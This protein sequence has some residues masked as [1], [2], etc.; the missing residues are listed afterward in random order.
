MADRKSFLVYGD[1]ADILC[2][3]SDEQAAELF[4]GMVDYFNTGEDPGFSGAMKF[5]WIPIR[6]QM[7]RDREKYENKCERN[8]TSA[9]KRWNANA[10]ERMQTHTNA[11]ERIRM[12]ANAG[13]IDTDT[14][15]DKDKDTDT[16]TDTEAVKS[17]EVCA[18]SVVSHLNKKAGSRYRVT[19]TVLE[20]IEDLLGAGYTE[21]DMK[22]VIDKKCSD[23]LKS[24]EMRRQLRPSVLFGSHFEEYLAAPLTGQA[25]QEQDEA[26]RK[27]RARK[28]KEEQAAREAALEAEHEAGRT[29]LSPEEVQ[30]RLAAITKKTFN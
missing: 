2:E 4:R 8:R 19:D 16:D 20:Q 27:E 11:S 7:D 6:Q 10:S 9:R 1:I 5:V 25:A 23:W 14:D 24:D 18:S 13:D 26:A 21:T 17:A 29:R 22:S 3:L 30:A 28:A 12:D 15:T